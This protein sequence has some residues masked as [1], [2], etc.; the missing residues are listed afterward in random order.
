[1]SKIQFCEQFVINHFILLINR[2]DTIKRNIIRQP[3]I[4]NNTVLQYSIDIINTI[5]LIIYNIIV[6]ILRYIIYK[7]SY[8]LIVSQDLAINS[9]IQESS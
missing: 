7:V 8:S 5:E 6:K 2:Y 1:M 3:D 9:S 4:I